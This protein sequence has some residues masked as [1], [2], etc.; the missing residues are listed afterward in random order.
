MKRPFADKR[1]IGPL[2]QLPSDNGIVPSVPSRFE[3]PEVTN[4][5]GQSDLEKDWNIEA[6]PRPVKDDRVYSSGLGPVEQRPIWAQGVTGAY[7]HK[8]DT[9]VVDNRQWMHHP[10]Q[11][12]YVAAGTN[13]IS[14]WWNA[15]KQDKP[16]LFAVSFAEFD[17]ATDGLKYIPYCDV[18]KEDVMMDAMRVETKDVNLEWI[19]KAVYACRL[20]DVPE[21]TE[22]T[23]KYG[24]RRVQ[25][26]E[27]KVE[28]G[29]LYR[30]LEFENLLP[31]PLFNRNADVDMMKGD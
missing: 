17:K 18:A 20:V 19:Y 5:I 6:E 1:P 28:M 25:T 31:E 27:K 22:V 14:E 3:P 23:V 21:Q 9:V 10:D 16:M 24:K 26:I 2:A 29:D 4:S 13:S 7:S 12:D 15:D 11:T 8:D 30:E